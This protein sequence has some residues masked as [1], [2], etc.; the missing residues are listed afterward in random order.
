MD[1]YEVVQ[2]VDADEP[3]TEADQ[4]LQACRY[5]DISLDDLK[6]VLEGNPSLADC[7]DDQGRTPMHMAAAN[8]HTDVAQLLIKCGALPN[9]T[10][11]EGYTALHY[12]AE[13]NQCPM[14]A[15]LTSKG[16]TVSARNVFG[17]TPLQLIAEKPFDEMEVILIKADDSLDTYVIKAEQGE[18]EVGPETDGGTTS[19][20]AGSMAMSAPTTAP[21]PATATSSATVAASKTEQVAQPLP[22]PTI[23]AASV[24]SAVPTGNADMDD[25]E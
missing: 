25:V 22:K 14:A 18:G 10:N 13:N 19:F 15:L 7:K 11:A 23:S 2:D 17:Q 6:T 4:V 21:R 20:S 5:N 9:A 24:A 3:I 12:A 8:G 1:R 16:W